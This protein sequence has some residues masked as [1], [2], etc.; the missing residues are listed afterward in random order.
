MRILFVWSG[1]TGYMGD[2]WRALSG[3]VELKVVVDPKNTM[4][5]GSFDAEKVMR[6]LDWG[7]RLP[8]NW[9]PDAVFTVG[10]HNPLCVAAAKKDW[11]ADVKRIC[12]FDMPWRTG[13]RCF[14]AKFA[15]WRHV[16]RFDAAYVAGRSAQ[17]YAK[18]LGFDD[19][20]TGLFSIDTKRFATPQGNRIGFLFVGRNAPEKGIDTLR[21]AY[22]IY[23]RNGGTW[24]LKAP[25]WT[26]PEDVPRL[27]HEH[28]CFVLP[29][30]WEPWGVVVAEAKAAGMKV[31]VSDRVHA[32]ED[33][34]CD[35]VFRAGDADELAAKML[36]MERMKTIVMENL[37]FW[38]CEAWAK[39]VVEIVRS[40][41]GLRGSRG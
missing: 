33:L 21:T 35:A 41:R 36:E 17:T 3:Q 22:G 16:R 15:L 9:I 1:L 31:I 6:G 27:M 34:A 40:S 30:K 26:E 25:E 28:A 37:D 13:L 2:C 20:R 4:P 10:W 7:T 29:S 18:W 19:V 8:D 38:S 39:R 14:A 11:G 32:R 5:G 23:K 24:P 12:C